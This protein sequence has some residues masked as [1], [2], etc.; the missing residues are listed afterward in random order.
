[1][2]A[3]TGSCQQIRGGNFQKEAQDSKDRRFVLFS[4]TCLLA[5]KPIVIGLLGHFIFYLIDRSTFYMYLFT[6][7]SYSF[8]IFVFFFYHCFIFLLSYLVFSS[9]ASSRGVSS[10][11]GP[12]SVWMTPPPPVAVF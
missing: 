5:L 3:R 6:P 8:G 1:M 10:L 9:S 7:L 12:L 4:F 2:H 11:W